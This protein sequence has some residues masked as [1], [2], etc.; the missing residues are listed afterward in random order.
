VVGGPAAAPPADGDGVAATSRG[1]RA[2]SVGVAAAIK[3]VSPAKRRRLQGSDSAQ[4]APSGGKD[5]PSPLES[6]ATAA[7]ALNT[8]LPSSSSPSARSIPSPQ[9]KKIE[10]PASREFKPDLENEDQLH[11]FLEVL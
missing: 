7:A 10:Y 3:S 6:P 11:F 2:A 9:Q 5:A 4:G 1:K 8:L